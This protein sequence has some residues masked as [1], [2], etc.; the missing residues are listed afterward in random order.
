MTFKSLEDKLKL[1]GCCV[2]ILIQKAVY[3]LTHPVAELDLGLVL[4]VEVVES[5]LD[6]FPSILIVVRI[7]ELIPT[8]DLEVAVRQH[9]ATL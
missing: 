1:K 3:V 7:L 9:I 4:V 5:H 8:Y 6:R 2:S